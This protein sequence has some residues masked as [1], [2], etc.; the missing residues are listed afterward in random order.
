MRREIPARASPAKSLSLAPFCSG[1][2]FY[3]VVVVVVGGSSSYGGGNALYT[4][5]P[6]LSSSLPLLYSTGTGSFQTAFATRLA[7]S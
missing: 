2:S 3:W 4:V 1:L 6:P 5:P 7:F